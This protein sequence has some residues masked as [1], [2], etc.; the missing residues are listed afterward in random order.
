MIEPYQIALT[1]ETYSSNLGD[2]VIAESLAHIVMEVMPATAVSCIDISG[3]DGWQ[4]SSDKAASGSTRS[5]LPPRLNNLLRWHVARKR[6]YSALWHPSLDNVS[7]LLVGGGQLLMDNALDFPIKVHAI[8]RAASRRNLPVHFVACGVNPNWSPRAKRL[9]HEALEY[10]TTISVRDTMSAVA[11]KRLIPQLDPHVVLDPAIWAADL[12]GRD[13]DTPHDS[14]VG[15][16]VMSLAA[17]NRRLRP[18]LTTKQFASIWEGIIR[19]LINQGHAVE[20]FTNGAGDDF[21]EAQQLS[22]SIKD[23]YGILCPV[24]PRPTRPKDLAWTI[25]RYSAVIAARLHANIIA[26]SYRIP[27]VGL[28]WDKKVGSF[29]KAINRP[30]HSLDLIDSTPEDVMAALQD[31]TANS[32]N[33]HELGALQAAAMSGVELIASHL[34]Q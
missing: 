14:L 27:T 16:G 12:Y 19:A 31:A 1:G 22:E 24:A 32:L 20:I 33:P 17:I 2:G 4:H 21:A 7:A 26:T 34:T 28:L 9:F 13:P 11:L 18:K 29:Y 30:N 8:V 15:V 25:S 3:R 10:A 6:R 23:R 5:L